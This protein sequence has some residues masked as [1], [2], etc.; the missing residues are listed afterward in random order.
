VNKIA[1]QIVAPKRDVVWCDGYRFAQSKPSNRQVI[2]P[3]ERGTGVYAAG[4][5]A[6][7]EEHRTWRCFL[8]CLPLLR[9]LETRAAGVIKP[10]RWRL[11][12]GARRGGGPI[13]VFA[14]WLKVFDPGPGE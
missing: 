2:M 11:P 10:S 9:P 4:V 12:V 8:L 5:L 6:A 1:A 13:T 7:E 14:H 3:H